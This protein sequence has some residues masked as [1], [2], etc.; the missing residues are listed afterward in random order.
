V[1]TP[2]YTPSDYP[3]LTFQVANQEYGLPVSDVIQIIE[4][5]KITALPQ[6]PPAVQGVINRRGQIVPVLDVR[7]RLGL[8]FRP[9]RLRTPII[10]VEAGSEW[11]GPLALVVDSVEA[12][13]EVAADL[14]SGN[15]LPNPLKVA[16][17]TLLGLAKVD[18]RLVPVL[19]AA[20]FLSDE[21]YGRL[22]TAE[23]MVS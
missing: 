11:S 21:E 9:Y 23:G 12:V 14:D 8:P 22:L 10:L 4:M 13:V 17:T 20:L 5:V 15:G 7:Q 3:I 19:N 6:M 16:A 18:N 1:N 2:S